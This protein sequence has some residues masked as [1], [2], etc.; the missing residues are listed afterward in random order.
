MRK[1]KIWNFTKSGLTFTDLLYYTFRVE[2]FACHSPFDYASNPVW[3]RLKNKDFVYEETKKVIYYQKRENLSYE[4]NVTHTVFYEMANYSLRISVP[5]M[6]TVFN[7]NYFIGF[8]VPNIFKVNESTSVELKFGEKLQQK[9]KGFFEEKFDE[10]S[11]RYY[12]YKFVLG[13][14]DYLRFV[15]RNDGVKFARLRNVILYIDVNNVE[16]NNFNNIILIDIYR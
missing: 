16:K 2:N 4:F 13:Y 6:D 11:E 5:R 8:K 9:V 12:F 1:L 10:D 14:E 15:G 3:L 7:P